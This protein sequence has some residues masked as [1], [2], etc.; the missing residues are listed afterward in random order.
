MAAKVLSIVIPAYNEERFVGTLLERIRAVDLESEGLRGEV[1]VVD[2]CSA[3]RTGEIAAAVPGVVLVRHEQNGGKGRAVRTGLDRAAGDYVIIQDADLEYDPDDYLP[4]L[5]TLLAGEADAVYGSRYLPCPERGALA[6]LLRGKHPDQSLL[7]YLGGQSLSFVCLFF[8][9]RYLT[10]TVTAFKLFR[11][12]DIKG[13][14]L[15]TTGFELDHEITAKL[16]AR[17]RS[18]GEVPI[19]YYP[20]SRAEGKKIGPRDW[21]IAIKTF[22]RYRRG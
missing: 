21:L 8:T 10:D 15:K 2:D 20:R 5:K 1:I 6:N 22:F 13:L 9:G 14:D 17:G 7:A 16:L 11:A 19:R 4:M 18:I 12:A 3:D